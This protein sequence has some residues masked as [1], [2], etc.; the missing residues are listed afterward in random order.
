MTNLKDTKITVTAGDCKTLTRKKCGDWHGWKK[1][2]G[3]LHHVTLTNNS[4]PT[5][6]PIQPDVSTTKI[7]PSGVRRQEPY[8]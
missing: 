1:S 7:F 2:N 8:T 4:R 6:K 5:R 3:K